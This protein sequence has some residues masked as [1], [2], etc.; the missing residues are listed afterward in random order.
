MGTGIPK[1]F[2]LLAGKPVL[3]H[4]IGL[5]LRFDPLM[6]I[7]LVLSPPYLKTW[8]EISG[9]YPWLSDVIIA[10]GGETRFHSVKNGL[11]LLDE[12]RIIGVHDAVRPL[13]SVKLLKRCYDQAA[14]TGN[15]LPA[16]EMK[17]SVRRVEG[18]KNHPLNRDSLKI[19][20]TPQVFKGELLKKA[21]L[22]DYS[23]E[24]TDEA[25]VVE[26]LGIEINLVEGEP[27]N[28]KITSPEDMRWAE[29]LAGF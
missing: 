22:A 29:C 23:E 7:V 16:I 5:F 13:A 11:A 28:I 20:Q 3:V 2:L 24:F 27:N 8:K 4:T 17:E 19:I 18:N 26:K 10:P 14:K 25:S 9:K 12:K 6:E 15:A 21:F 1:Q